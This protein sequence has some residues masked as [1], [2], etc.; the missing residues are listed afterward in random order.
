[1][2]GRRS[3]ARA[4]SVQGASDLFNRRRLRSLG[5]ITTRA[6]WTSHSR[7]EKTYR[8]MNVPLEVYVDLVDAE[9]KDEFFHDNIEDRLVHTAVKAG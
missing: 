2:I 5:T 7:A 4:R 8:C 9:S 3:T 1:N 6:N